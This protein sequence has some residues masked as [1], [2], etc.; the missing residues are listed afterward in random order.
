MCVILDIMDGN[1]STTGLPVTSEED[2]GRWQTLDS[3]ASV[4]PNGVL[5]DKKAKPPAAPVCE[6]YLL[7]Q[8]PL[9]GPGG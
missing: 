8:G 4:W 6:L 2:A 5:C 1:T 9:Q 3:K 7:I